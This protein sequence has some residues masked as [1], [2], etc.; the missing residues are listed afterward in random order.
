[1]YVGNVGTYKRNK[2]LLTKNKLKKFQTILTKY[3][4]YKLD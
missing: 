1:M 4:F 2:N 3:L